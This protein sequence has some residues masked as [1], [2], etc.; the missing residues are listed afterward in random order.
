MTN[1]VHVS[2]IIFVT[3]LNQI[4]TFQ[5]FVMCIKIK[6]SIL[7]FE[8]IFGTIRLFNQ[9]KNFF[10]SFYFKKNIFDIYFS[11]GKKLKILKMFLIQK[12]FLSKNLI[13]FVKSLI[14][15]TSENFKII[16]FFDFRKNVID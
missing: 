15:L 3:E 10:P 11:S 2:C 12:K 1:Y 4:Q 5:S 16:E 14:L 7:Q 13:F 6:D 9:I 8:R